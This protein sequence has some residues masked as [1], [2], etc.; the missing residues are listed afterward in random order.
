M[1]NKNIILVLI[2]IFISFSVIFAQEGEQTFEGIAANSQISNIRLNGFEDASFWEVAMP[3]DQGIITKR[4]RRGAPK[5]IEN[6][7]PYRVEAKVFEEDVVKNIKD[8]EDASFIQGLYEKKIDKYTIADDDGALTE[9]VNEYYTLKEDGVTRDKKKR[10]REILIKN[11][12]DKKVPEVYARDK[13][14]GVKVEFIARGYNWFSIKPIKPIVIEGRC[15]SISVWVA[16]RSYKHVLKMIILDL[17][18]NQRILYVGKLNF[19][20]WKQLTAY[21]PGNNI[22]KQ[23]DHHYVD[24]EGIKFNGFLIECDPVETFGSYY[25]YFDELRAT[26]DLF[27]ESTRDDDD[28]RDDW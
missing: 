6:E 22:V 11:E 1:Y 15:Q 20:G 9:I 3:I 16:G 24:K 8:G 7:I 26:T 10:A 28:M 5:D 13:V 21:I 19:T 2:I 4:S 23:W 17:F 25:I 18:N 14:L 12:I 27:S